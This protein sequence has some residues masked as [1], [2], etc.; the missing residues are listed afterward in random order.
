MPER[1]EPPLAGPTRGNKLPPGVSRHRCEGEIRYRARIRL[2]SSRRKVS[3]GLFDTMEEAI[4]AIEKEKAR[5]RE[6]RR[7]S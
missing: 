2:P 4:A 3:L 6:G 5:Q 1:L 7:A